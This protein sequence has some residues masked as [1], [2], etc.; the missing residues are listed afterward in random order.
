[1]T[2]FDAEFDSVTRSAPPRPVEYGDRGRQRMMALRHRGDRPGGARRVATDQPLRV[3][4]RPGLADRHLADRRRGGRDP[5]PPQRSARWP[6]PPGSQGGCWSPQ[7]S[8]CSYGPTPPCGPSPWWPDRPRPGRLARGASSGS[9]LN[10]GGRAGARGGAAGAGRP[11]GPGGAGR[12]RRGAGGR[13]NG[14]GPGGNG[15]GGEGGGLGGR[16]GERGGGQPDGAMPERPPRGS[17]RPTKGEVMALHRK[18]IEDLTPLVLSPM[19]ARPGE[20]AVPT[21][22]RSPTSRRPRQPTSSCTTS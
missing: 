2:D 16:G 9:E 15:G 5:G 20:A 19:Y 3:R 18:L 8:R 17:K 21:G 4:H 13:G 1:M 7:G 10:G 14:P 12:R 11:G 22:T 6:P